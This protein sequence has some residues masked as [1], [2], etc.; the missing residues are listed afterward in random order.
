MQFAT[1]KTRDKND[2]VSLVNET[3]CT[4]CTEDKHVY[5]MI[6]NDQISS[7]E[8]SVSSDNDEHADMGIECS[9]RV[10]RSER[11]MSDC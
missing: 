4:S 9:P 1:C 7:F 6:D 2:E 5:D 3:S 8:L 10:S 11:T